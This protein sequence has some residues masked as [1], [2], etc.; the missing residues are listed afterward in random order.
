MVKEQK[1]ELL[2]REI[3]DIRVCRYLRSLFDGLN[4]EV[5]EDDKGSIFDLMKKNK[6]SGWSW[7]TTET[8][9]L[10]MPD[11]AMV[12]R[13]KIYI[14]S[15]RSYLHSFIQF[16]FDN[17]KYVFDPCLGLINTLDEYLY[18]LG[19][20]A[21][22]KVSAKDIKDYFIKNVK[23]QSKDNQSVIY[24]TN[25]LAKQSNCKIYKDEVFFHDKED[26]YAPMYRNGSGYKNISINK[27][28]IKG[29][30]VH[31]YISGITKK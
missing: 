4:I 11:D 29:L 17:K 1:I 14:Q 27:N 30:T 5:N 25:M 12:Y 16:N 28:N 26:P 10:F 23:E 18:E 31:Y 15:Y 24:S 19:A 22:G 3:L 21:I 7:Q 2:K 20:E 6:L 8:A 13:A 9:A